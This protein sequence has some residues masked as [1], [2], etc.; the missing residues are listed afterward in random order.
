MIGIVCAFDTSAVS[1]LS[2]SLQVGLPVCINLLALAFA[3]VGLGVLV[4]YAVA[5]WNASQITEFK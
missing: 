2:G 1:A 4:K 5:E 3:V